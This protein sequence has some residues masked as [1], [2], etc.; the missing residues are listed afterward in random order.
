MTKS[1]ATPPPAFA[2]SVAIVTGASSGIGAATACELARRGTIVVAVA[3]RADKLDEVVAKCHKWSPKSMAHAADVSDNYSCD[4]VVGDAIKKFGHVNIIVN[5]AGVAV[6][7]HAADETVADVE[8]M[9]QV[10]FFGAVHM[11]LAALPGMIERGSGSIINVTSVAGYIPNPREAA[12]GA[13]KAA[14]SRWSH[15][16]AV[17]LHDTGVHVGVLSP[18]PINTDIWEH[19]SDVDYKGKLYSPEL[20]ASGVTKMIERR[21]THL[22]VPRKFGANGALYPLMGRPMRYGMRKFAERNAVPA[23]D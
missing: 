17:D 4:S 10:N 13:S 7:K 22:T 15:G 9:M 8:L 23:K 1:S 16:L 11:T 19:E 21:I 2:D 5:N 18:G 12:Y 6:N 20:V 3:R 14:L